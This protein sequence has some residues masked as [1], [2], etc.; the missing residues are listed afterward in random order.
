MAA[1]SNLVINMSDIEEDDS[2]VFSSGPF[3]SIFISFNIIHK[4]NTLQQIKFKNYLLICNLG[5]ECYME[6]TSFF[7]GD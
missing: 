7:N 1:F 3:I 2:E 4:K 5:I 6:D